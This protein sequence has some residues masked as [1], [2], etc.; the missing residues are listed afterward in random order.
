LR[1]LAAARPDSSRASFRRYLDAV[2]A[3]AG[4]SSLSRELAPV[5][6]GEPQA[7]DVFV[8]GGSPGHAVIVVDTA[9][10][11]VSGRRAFLLAQSYMPAQEIHVLRNPARGEHPWY[12]AT[13]GEPLA[14]PEW[15]FPR[16]SLRR[17]RPVQ[18]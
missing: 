7:G 11:P 4:S 17:F 18:R 15:R 6:D 5:A 12:E 14:T 10:D 8:Q 13:P 16:D 9:R 3:F 1:W 2:F